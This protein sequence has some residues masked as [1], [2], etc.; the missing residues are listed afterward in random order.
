MHYRH[1]FPVWLNRSIKRG[2][3]IWRRLRERDSN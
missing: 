3:E 2:V 1:D